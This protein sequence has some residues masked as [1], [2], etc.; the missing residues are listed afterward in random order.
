M[1]INPGW[2]SASAAVGGIVATVATTLIRGAFA[3]RDG[4]IEALKSTQKVLFDKLDNVTTALN[5]YK[6]HVAETYVNEGNL[7]K[8][9]EPISRRLESIEDDLRGARLGT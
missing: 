9:L 4:R 1:D 3:D 6:L 7:E 2:V 8:L 5:D